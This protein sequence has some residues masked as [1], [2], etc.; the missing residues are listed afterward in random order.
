MGTILRLAALVIIAS[1]LYQSLTKPGTLT[2]RE[3]F[4][5]AWVALVFLALARI[6]T[7]ARRPRVS[8][9]RRSVLR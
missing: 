5:A 3:A 1:A 7:P 9:R 6:V 4:V 8:V 2:Q